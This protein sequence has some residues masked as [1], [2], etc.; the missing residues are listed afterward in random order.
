[1]IAINDLAVI[2]DGQTICAVSRL[3]VA[4]GDHLGVRGSNGAGK[5]TLIRVIAGLESD[6]NGRCDVN[7]PRC[8]RVLVHQTP[9]L[10]RGTVLDN[11]V[12]GLRARG[13]G[14][15]RCRDVAMNWLEKLGIAELALRRIDHLSG[16]ERRRT[17][18]VRAL[19]LEPRLLLLDE[20]FA[21]MDADGAARVIATLEA[22]S[23]T[24]IIA[25]SP[26]GF[27]PGV[28]QREFHIEQASVVP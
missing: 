8:D 26:T 2:K 21:E 4:P 27:P 1:M 23:D 18:L 5:T 9:Y 17:A 6:F 22:L 24:T 3:V 16:G 11:A 12:Y 28:T 20:P 10:F 15:Q 7:V 14:R 13:V 25:T 19:V